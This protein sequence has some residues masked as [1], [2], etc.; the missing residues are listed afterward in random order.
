MIVNGRE[1]IIKADF[2]EMLD[3]ILEWL[4]LNGYQNTAQV[5]VSELYDVIVK[6]IA[7]NPERF[8]EY[9]WKRTPDKIYRRFLFRK[10]WYIVYKV[11]PKRLE[12]LVIVYS[13]RDLSKISFE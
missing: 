1:I 2:D 11:H 8:P 12:F 9:A 3:G 13:R 10:K 4:N 7:P 6:K 5:F